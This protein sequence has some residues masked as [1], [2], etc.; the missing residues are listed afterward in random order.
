MRSALA[1]G[2]LIALCAS[3]D[4]ETVHHSARA[5]FGPAYRIIPQRQRCGSQQS[6]DLTSATGQKR[7]D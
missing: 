7:N 1:F 4:A 6:G 5:T 3:A 2:L